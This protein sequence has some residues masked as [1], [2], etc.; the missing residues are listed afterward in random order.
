M[1][2]DMQKS[3]YGEFKAQIIEKKSKF[4]AIASG[5]NSQEQAKEFIDTQR[6]IYYDARHVVYA[7]ILKDGIKKYSDDKEPSKTAGIPILKV[8]EYGNFF[9]S[10]IVVVRYFGGILLGE[11]GLIR[12]YSG[13]A[14]KVLEKAIVLENKF[15]EKIVINF[16]YD[17]L[18]KINYEL[19][20]NNCFISQRIF[21]SKIKLVF[22]VPKENADKILNEL[23]KISN[24]KLTVES[25][26]KVFGTVA[27]K[28]FIN[29]GEY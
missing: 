16:G 23:I 8:L 12:A 9:Y 26:T 4:I 29:C 14:K 18:N 21:D 15:Y 22:Y 11:G 10:I 2:C 13:A 17:N 19:E 28:K 27:N 5:V 6:K 7:Y 1:W 20:K 25:R 3:I 24:A